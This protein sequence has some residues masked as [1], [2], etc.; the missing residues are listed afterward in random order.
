MGKKL[1]IIVDLDGT[2]ALF[3][4]RGP[5]EWDK[6]SSDIPNEPVIE[7][8]RRFAPTHDIL[9]VTGRSLEA[10]ADTVAWLRFHGVPYQELMMPRLPGD[11]R[12]DTEIKQLLW[13]RSIRDRYTVDFCL[14][15]RNQS[16]DFWRALGLICL[17]VA[18]GDF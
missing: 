18:P 13:E 6:V 8:V 14:D 10:R 11:Y 5:F 3:N 9:I 4:G 1:A 17:Q 2:I 7:I 12:K 16:V 15:D